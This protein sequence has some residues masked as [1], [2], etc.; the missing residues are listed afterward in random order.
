M[1]PRKRR[2]VFASLLE[3]DDL[4]FVESPDDEL[5]STESDVCGSCGNLRKLHEEGVEGSVLDSG[6][7]KKFR[8]MR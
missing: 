8:E 2:S 7:C 6:K 1:P 5:S 3:D 4:A